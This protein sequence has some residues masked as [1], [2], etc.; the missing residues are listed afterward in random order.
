M[1]TKIALSMATATIIAA[2]GPNYSGRDIQENSNTAFVGTL[3]VP[4]D[5]T[6]VKIRYAP[7]YQDIFVRRAVLSNTLFD[8]FMTS[9]QRKSMRRSGH[10]YA[11]DYTQVDTYSEHVSVSGDWRM[12]RDLARDI[13]LLVDGKKVAT[14]SSNPQFVA[15]PAGNR[16]VQVVGYYCSSMNKFGASNCENN[17]VMKE[18][19]LDLEEGDQKEINV[20]AY[21]DETSARYEVVFED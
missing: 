15:L 17:Q 1:N 19:R 2:C 16:I 9:N 5:A 4:Y 20:E 3:N 11:D 21:F 8:E 18:F 14:F 7:E 12:V 6:G 13:S 10:Y